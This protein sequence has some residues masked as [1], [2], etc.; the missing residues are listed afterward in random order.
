[1]KIKITDIVIPEGRRTIDRDK[2]AALAE[3]IKII[4]GL[5]HPIIIGKDRSLIAG[6]HRIEAY[7]ILGFDE[8]ECTEFDGERLEAEL[9]EID[10]NL[11]R[12]ELD[13]I[14]VGEIVIR[15]DEIL[16]ELGL[17][18]KVGQGRPAKNGASDAPFLQTTAD[19]A[20]EVGISERTLQENKQLAKNLIPEVKESRREKRITK[21]AA[22][23][24]SRLTPEQQR[25][26]LAKCEQEGSGRLGKDGKLRPAKYA[27][28]KKTVAK[29]SEP[30]VS[31]DYI[32]LPY[33]HNGEFIK[34][35]LPI[36]CT[37][38]SN[39]I[40][41]KFKHE[42]RE[43]RERIVKE[44]EGLAVIIRYLVRENYN[45]NQE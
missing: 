15:R 19:I 31:D 22:L 1:M 37:A 44:I 41:N 39:T 23:T 5:I 26:T 34:F 18:A 10:E 27:P 38:M 21:D 45:E 12:N 36:D 2:V 25:E 7:K 29:S 42:S 6:A 33:H 3:S 40:T 11:M 4:G 14:T 32:D 35:A 43:T 28:R 30:V 24:M 8:I 16:E 17:R 20:K 9:V 13:D